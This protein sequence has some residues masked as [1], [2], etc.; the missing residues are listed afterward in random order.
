MKQQAIGIRLPQ[1]LLKQIDRLS[2]QEMEDRS[3][4]IRKLVFIGYISLRKERAVEAYRRGQLTFS[5]A[6]KAAGLTPWEMEQALVE[7]GVTSTY[8]IA[9]LERETRLLQQRH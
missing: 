2:R 7:H 8:T 5:A 9:D 6:A 1:L 4:V 3:T